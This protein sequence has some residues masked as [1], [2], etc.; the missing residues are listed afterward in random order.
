[1][2]KVAVVIEEGR[3]AGM[4]VAVDDKGFTMMH[5]PGRDPKEEKF[6][7]FHDAIVMNDALRE[8]LKEN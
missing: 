3:Y 4:V 8:I 2:A 1:M 6:V 5:I 7:D